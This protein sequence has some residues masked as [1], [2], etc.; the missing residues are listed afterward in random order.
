MKLP[1]LKY[2]LMRYTCICIVEYVVFHKYSY[3]TTQSLAKYN[4]HVLSNF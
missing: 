1:E 4:L 2:A 3:V